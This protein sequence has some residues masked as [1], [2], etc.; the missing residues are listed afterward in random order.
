[1]EI[2]DKNVLKQFGFSENIWRI[3]LKSCNSLL[4]LNELEDEFCLC[5]YCFWFVFFLSFSFFLSVVSCFLAFI[6]SFNM[7]F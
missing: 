4:F 3:F 7:L 1:M 2:C 5:H 6:C